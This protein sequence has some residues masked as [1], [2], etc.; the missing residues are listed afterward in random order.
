MP[1]FANLQEHAQT[2]RAE[3]N[4]HNYF[5]YVID[6]PKISDAEYDQLFHELLQLEQQYPALKTLDSPTQRVGAKPLP[7]F[8]SVTHRL[9]ML[10]LSN[11][12]NFQ[13]L[14]AFH[15][16]VTDKLSATVEYICEPKLDGLAISLRYL[17]GILV[18]AATRG[19]G[20]TGEDVTENCRTIKSIPLRLHA[21]AEQNIP[22]VLEVR[23]E[24]YLPISGFTQLNTVLWQK[25]EKIFANPRNAA[26][27]SL[28]QLDARIAATRPLA[29]FAY[30]IGEVSRNIATTQQ[31]AL[32]QL[33]RWGFPVFSEI[34]CATTPVEC[35]KIY[36]H[37]MQQR[38][39]LDVE[40]D[41]MVIK[42]NS[43][44]QQEALGFLS[45]SPRW[46]TAYKFPAEEAVTIIT[47]IKAQVGRTGALTPVAQ[48]NP[49]TVG[50]VVVSKATLHNWDELERKDIRVGDHVLVRRAG[51]V[52]PEIV[53][54]FLEKRKI[55]AEKIAIPTQCPVC[56]RQV[57]KIAGEAI[58]RCLGGMQCSAQRKEGLR[59]FASR[60]AM[61]IEGLGDQ[62]IEQLVDANLVKTPADLYHL[63]LLQLAALERMGEKSA[64]N[65]VHAVQ[66]SK[67]TL[68][69]RLIYALGIR[70]VGEA[71]ARHLVQHFKTLG[72]IM[73]ASE[74]DLLQVEDIGPVVAKQVYNFFQDEQHKNL[75]QDLIAAGVCWPEKSESATKSNGRMAGKTVVITGT[76]HAFS[77]E[78]L[79]E[80]LQALGAKIS[81]AV[82]KKTDY[83]IVG[84]NP[85]SKLYKAQKLG[86]PLLEE[87]QL[88]QEWLP[89][90]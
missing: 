68:L 51:D 8:M 87:A 36:E 14:M 6:D 33:K 83:V 50:G 24:V 21:V 17:Q 69:N 45:R 4:Q 2:L 65:I 32:H 34:Q 15:Q 70:D 39:G 77:R 20:E 90:K 37:W 30:G 78:Q 9:P 56:C 59:H 55:Y 74:Q 49:V 54:V 5:Y 67:N 42:I 84:E 35:Q 46:A 11:V 22:E 19:D 7:K 73:Q 66:K 26:A 18:T 89:V 79:K 3:L 86:I 40:I 80:K 13:E 23:G 58:L 27:G 1:S 41:G 47:A 61:D 10:S 44:V 72:N 76:L 52:I 85:G 48:L 31:H 63:S 60:R 53:R 57:E 81:D 25:N 75:I 38:S 43:F 16:R 29:F 28:R 12:F 71:T 64:Q 88:L 82:S 62:R